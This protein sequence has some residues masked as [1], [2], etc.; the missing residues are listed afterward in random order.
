MVG[1]GHNATKLKKIKPGAAKEPK[2]ASRGKTRLMTMKRTIPFLLSF[3]ALII[4]GLSGCI[5]D[6]CQQ[7]FTYIHYEPVYMTFEELRASGQ[8]EAA[9]DLVHPG[10]LYYKTGFIFINEIQEGIHVIDNRD[11]SNPQNIAFINIPG[12]HDLAAKGNVLYTDSY[13]DL[14]AIDISDP[15]NTRVLERVEDVFPYGMWHDGLSADVEYGVA[16]DWIESEITEEIPCGSSGGIGIGWGVG[17]WRNTF[18]MEDVAVLANNA[19]NTQFGG[20]GEVSTGIGGSMARF[21]IKND[22]LYTVNMQGLRSF[23]ISNLAQPVAQEEVFMGWGIETIYPYADYLLIGSQNGMF[24]YGL[25]NPAMPNELGRF[26]H[27]R[28][29]DPVVADNDVAYVTLRGGTPCEGFVNQLDVLDISSPRNPQ[30]MA[31][32]PMTEPYGLGIKDD[33][34]FICEGEH[35]LSV[36]DATDKYAITDNRLAHFKKIHAFDVIPL[37]NVLLM[38]GQDGFFQYDYSDVTNIKELSVIPV[39][40]N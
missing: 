6:K 11:P 39:V 35:G 24:I 3:S 37:I 16:I 19:S 10:K 17:P 32:Y 5:Q 12:S 31:S 21:T 13:T 33:I 22:Y 40:G 14:V 4:L 38:I 26:E 23:D 8:A 20:S 29:C 25:D 15:T 28:S 9:R 2:F 18:M 27:V 36:Y 1:D 7:E 30:L 34:L